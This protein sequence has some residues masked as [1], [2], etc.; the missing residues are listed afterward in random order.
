MVTDAA[1]RTASKATGFS[2]HTAAA[3]K[4]EMEADGSKL[5]HLWEMTE[6]DDG[7]R[8]LTE[9]ALEEAPAGGGATAEEVRIEMDSNS[10]QFTAIVE[11]T[12]ELQTDWLNGG[13]LDNLLDTAAS[14]GSSS[15]GEGAY[16]GT[17]I[18]DD[19]EGN[20]LAGAVVVARRSGIVK[21][22]G[23]TDD[24]GQITDWVFDAYTYDLAV[25]LDSYQ[26]TTDTLAVSADDWEKTISLSA[27]S[28]TSP[29]A[30]SLCTVQFRVMLS[31][32]AVEGAVCKAKLQGINQAS[33]GTLLSNEELSSTTSA[34]GVAELQLVRKDSIVKGN[35]IYKI[36]VEIAGKPVASVETT[37]PGQSVILF[38]D[39]L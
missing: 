39:L 2:T 28:I 1:S 18:V 27:M 19:G 12:N 34:L 4:T 35:G 13:R 38:E 32:T 17:L 15:T 5:D 25:R 6:D 21:A 37:I 31:A 23:T 7:T 16:T 36:W 30:I 26:P 24:D 11:D 20:G 10:T 14:R 9:N 8:R 29:S 33:D 22:S 3:V